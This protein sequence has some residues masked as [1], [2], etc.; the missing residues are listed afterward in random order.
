MS[1]GSYNYAYSKIDELRNWVSTLRNMAERVRGW[2]SCDYGVYVKTSGKQRPI[3]LEERARVL[4]HAL[5]LDSAAS[6]LEK[7]VEGVEELETTMQAVEWIASG[8]SS[9]DVLFKR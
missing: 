2:A 9:I 3:T 5:L 4:V 8:D 7:A 6:R 1:G